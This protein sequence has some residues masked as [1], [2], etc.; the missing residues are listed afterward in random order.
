MSPISQAAFPD[1]PS[2]EQPLSLAHPG[3]S[4]PPS[5]PWALW[6]LTARSAS[7]TE[8]G[9][10]HAGPAL[11]PPHLLPPLSSPGWSPEQQPNENSD[12]LTEWWTETDSEGPRISI[13]CVNCVSFRT[14][15]N[16][17]ALLLSHFLGS[18]S[19]SLL[20]YLFTP[21]DDL[22]SLF[23]QKIRFCSASGAQWLSIAVL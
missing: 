8:L 17:T 13:F 22:N 3:F 19:H 16:E 1:I 10:P 20:P 6:T 15:A 2:V 5:W 9:A 12:L 23:L 4:A 21:S 18:L 7:L 11:S 14:G